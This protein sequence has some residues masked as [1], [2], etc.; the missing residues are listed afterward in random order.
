MTNIDVVLLAAGLS[1]RMGDEN[2]L[3]LPF[4][5]VPLVRHTA[6]TILASGC[7][8]LV[9]VTGH[10]ADAVRS[11]LDGLPLKTL[12]NPDYASGQMSTVA[13]GLNAV[14]STSPQPEGVMIALA[15]MPYLQARDYCSLAGVFADKV[16]RKIIVPEFLG[17]RGNPVILPQ[18]LCAQA[19]RGG[20][21]SGCRHLIDK[22]PADVQAADMNNSA[23][24][25]DID[26]AADY[27]RAMSSRFPVAPCCG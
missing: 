9:V 19:A 14:L 18:Q 27:G 23:F 8:S 10:E 20:I 17:K 25:T 13:C 11:A 2:K 12:F 16:C 3:L 6:Q 5:G 21:R 7:R 4:E 26:T 1:R 22:R 15:D 24:I